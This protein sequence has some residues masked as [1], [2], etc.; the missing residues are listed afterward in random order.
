MRVL[1]FIVEGR[2]IKPDPSCDF[3][4]LFP[5]RNKSIKVEFIFSPEWEKKVKVAAFW[6]VMGAEFPPQT[7]KDDNTCMI[8]IEALDKS[9]FK[10]QILGKYRGS[11]TF[12]NSFTV[13]QKGG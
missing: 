1:Q 3:N 7:I 12:T 4:G 6:S 8:P 10:I 11:T 2:T 9:A 13:Y 5:G